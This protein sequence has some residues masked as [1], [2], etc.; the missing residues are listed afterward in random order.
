MKK[1]I[2]IAAIAFA[3]LSVIAPGA[4]AG[5]TSYQ[6]HSTEP[7]MELIAQ[8]DEC[9]TVRVSSNL[10]DAMSRN[11]PEAP[12]RTVYGRVMIHIDDSCTGDRLFGIG[13][14]NEITDDELLSSHG[15]EDAS[16]TVNVDFYQMNDPV[17][18]ADT[19]DLIGTGVAEVNWTGVGDHFVSQNKEEQGKFMVLGRNADVDFTLTFED[20]GLD[21]EF[22][23]ASNASTYGLMLEYHQQGH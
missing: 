19:F 11:S 13:E 4:H 7:E 3:G 15:L 10:S 20:E 21:E 5:A 2:S 22:F 6:S 12:F 23:D 18:G 16:L 1:T 8:L 9:R 14:L 17:T